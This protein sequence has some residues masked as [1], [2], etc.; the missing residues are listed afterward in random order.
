VSRWADIAAGLH[1]LPL[2]VTSGTIIRFFYSL[3]TI[4]RESQSGGRAMFTGIAFHDQVSVLL[5][6]EVYAN[7]PMA[8]KTARHAGWQR[9]SA[10]SVHVQIADHFSVF[11]E[12]LCRAGAMLRRPKN[13]VT[14]AL[15]GLQRAGMV[16]FFLWPIALPAFFVHFLCV[17]VILQQPRVANRV[18]RR[19]A[20]CCV[21][22]RVFDVTLWLLTDLGVT[23]GELDGKAETAFMPWAGRMPSWRKF[24]RQWVKRT[25]RCLVDAT[26]VRRIG[27]AD[28]EEG[29]AQRGNEGDGKLVAPPREHCSERHNY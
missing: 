22:S 29:G 12:N 21:V 28:E 3:G 18:F 9:F 1:R 25:Q 15:V 26:R 5:Y 23:L 27:A 14:Q 10:L 2:F 6:A 8:W 24:L 20:A 17:R 7:L 19:V 16:H 11:Q 13:N 4:F